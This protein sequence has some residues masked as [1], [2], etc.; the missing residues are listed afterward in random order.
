[1]YPGH[2]LSLSLSPSCNL[3]IRPVAK[4]PGHKPLKTRKVHQGSQS[5][6]SVTRRSPMPPQHPPRTLP[7]QRRRKKNPVPATYLKEPVAPPVESGDDGGMDIAAVQ[8][9]GREEKREFSWKEGR[10]EGR[11]TAQQRR[12]EKGHAAAGRPGETEDRVGLQGLGSRMDCGT[13][14]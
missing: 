1:M 3:T 4:Q 5:K 7:K 13:C 11:K 12:S 6:A 10:K 14:Q 8:A 2:Q 9:L